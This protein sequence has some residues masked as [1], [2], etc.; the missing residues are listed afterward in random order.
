MPISQTKSPKTDST[1]DEVR[2]PD[3]ESAIEKGGDDDE[4]DDI[5]PVDKTGR[6]KRRR[7]L[8]YWTCCG[9]LASICPSKRREWWRDC[10]LSGV[11]K[12]PIAGGFCAPTVSPERSFLRHLSN[13]ST[14]ICYFVFWKLLCLMEQNWLCYKMGGIGWRFSR[15]RRKQ[16]M[17]L[18][19]FI[20][21]IGGCIIGLALCGVATDAYTLR[22]FPWGVGKGSVMVEMVPTN[23]VGDESSPTSPAATETKERSYTIRRV[24]REKEGEDDTETRW[25]SSSNNTDNIGGNDE[26]HSYASSSSDESSTHHHTR[27]HIIEARYYM[28]ILQRYIDVDVPMEI[29]LHVMQEQSPFTRRYGVSTRRLN[30]DTY[31]LTFGKRWS[32]GCNFADPQF[33]DEA[34]RSDK[35]ANVENSEGTMTTGGNGSDGSDSDDDDDDHDDDDDD[36]HDHDDTPLD[37][38][39]AYCTH[40]HHDMVSSFGF[41]IILF[42]INWFTIFGLAL[43]GVLL[44]IPS[45]ATNMQRITEFGDLN[46]Q[47]SLGMGFAVMSIYGCLDGTIQF[48]DCYHSAPASIRIPEIGDSNDVAI[49]LEWEL[50]AAWHLF[51]VGGMFKICDLIFHTVIQTPPARQLKASSSPATLGEFMQN[52]GGGPP[53]EESGPSPASSN[54]I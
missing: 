32:E 14:V 13:E 45:I 37:S 52:V 24:E 19:T 46:C 7:E 38:L 27:R 10:C 35:N 9:P 44:Q 28:G 34:L 4:D 20:S 1:N 21:L 50:G 29:Y 11:Y 23:A 26:A 30:E 39:P 15:T 2:N 43:L 42:V 47:K 22:L 25:G 54:A 3:L 6:A 5:R 16:L 12:I 18:G 51:F 36:D 53:L 49:P 48:Q 40:C 31:R 17:S 33:E 8:R 41:V